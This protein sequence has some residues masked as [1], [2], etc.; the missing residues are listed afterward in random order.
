MPN[1][2]VRPSEIASIGLGVLPIGA[3][4]FMMASWLGWMR[5]A[6]ANMAPGLKLK[7]TSTSS[8]ISVAPPRSS[9]ALMIC[10]QVVAFMPPK[11]T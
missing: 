2:S 6:S 3:I 11:V 9:A 4:D 1:I 10:T 5:T 8:A 7:C